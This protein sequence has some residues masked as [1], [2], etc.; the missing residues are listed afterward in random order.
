M[1]TKSIE[2]RAINSCI[3]NQ[4]HISYNCN[5]SVTETSYK[6]GFINGVIEERERCIKIAQDKMCSIC[7]AA[8]NSC[9]YGVICTYGECDEREKLRKAIEEGDKI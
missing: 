6:E 9:G 3:E 8:H 2:E 4:P 7:R 1:E 5:E